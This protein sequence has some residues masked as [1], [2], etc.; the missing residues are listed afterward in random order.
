M[1]YFSCPDIVVVCDP[2]E[3]ELRNQESDTLLNPTLLIEIFS[4]LTEDW[5]RELRAVQYRRCS[6]LREYLVISEVEPF[7]EQYV[8]QVDDHWA[9]ATTIGLDATL[10]MPSINCE[11]TFETL[12]KD[13]S[14][15]L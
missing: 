6:S 8:R 7:V 4:P 13:V 1:Q 11:I 14:V 10:R 9:L 3:L 12:Y 2:P 5:D 15:P